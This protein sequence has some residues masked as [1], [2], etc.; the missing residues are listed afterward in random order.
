MT[1]QTI[2]FSQQEVTEIRCYFDKI[3]SGETQQPLRGSHQESPEW[4][5]VFLLL[6]KLLGYGV[7]STTQTD[8]KISYEALQKKSQKPNDMLVTVH[9]HLSEFKNLL[10][11]YTAHP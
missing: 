4:N 11:A 5:T 2:Q 10:A 3:D 7:Y 6:R 8:Q 1:I 9:A